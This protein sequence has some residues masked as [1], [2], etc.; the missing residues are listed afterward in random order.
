MLQLAFIQS[1]FKGTCGFSILVWMLPV[2]LILTRKILSFLVVLLLLY[3]NNSYLFLV[4]LQTRNTFIVYVLLA[5][6]DSV[7]FNNSLINILWSCGK[8]ECMFL[9][10]YLIECAS[11]ISKKPKK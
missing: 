8:D 2:D 5:T 6:A 10:I 11:Q 3:L 9:L 7:Y 4:L 1:L